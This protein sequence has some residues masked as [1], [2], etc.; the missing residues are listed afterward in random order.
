MEE[1]KVKKYRLWYQIFMVMGIFGIIDVASKGMI[2]QST[3]LAGIGVI[4]LA[5]LYIFKFLFGTSVAAFFAVLFSAILGFSFGWLVLAYFMNKKS[6]MLENPSKGNK[7]NFKIA[8]IITLILGA[9]V[10]V[11]MLFGMF[12]VLFAVM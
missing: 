8:K 10:L 6:K 12:S 9:I 7:K 1:T 2:E 3:H 11:L 4:S 5:I